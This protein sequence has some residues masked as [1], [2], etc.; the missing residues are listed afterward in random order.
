MALVSSSLHRTQTGFDPDP[1]AIER[2]VE[3][4]TYTQCPAYRGDGAC[5][6]GCHSEPY[7]QTGEPT[8]GWVCYA[9]NLLTGEADT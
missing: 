2:A 4:L 7:C 6:S 5:Q 9:L 1:I 8:G 3:A